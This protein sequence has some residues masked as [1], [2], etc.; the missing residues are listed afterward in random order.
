MGKFAR[1]NYIFILLLVL[2][3]LVGCKPE[4]EKKDTSGSYTVTDIQGTTVTIPAKPKRILT[5]S[6]ST[7]EMMLGLVEPERMVAVNSLLDD[8][9]SSNM[10]E[11]GKQVPTKIKYPSVEE[12]AALQPDLVIEP[13]WGDLSRV[14]ALRDL[15]IPVVVCKGPK[16]LQDIKETI[17]L[18]AQAVGEPQRGDILLKKM[19]EKLGEIKSKVAEIPQSERKS[20]LLISLMKDYGGAGCAFDEACQL[21]GVINGAAAAGIQNGQIMTK[22]K[23]VAINPDF[24]FLPS[25]NNHGEVDINRIRSEYINDPGLQGMKAIKNGALLMPDEGYIY[26]CSQD[27]VFAVQ[28][29]AYRVYGDKFKLEPQQHLSAVER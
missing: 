25:Y 11:L 4:G 15:G 14:A 29:I 21:A 10:V 5:M 19:D 16:N 1:W 2:I 28:E 18:L 9:S 12:I 23:M 24:L 8:P 22:E 7:D 13:D 6:M 27:F 20:V 26:N 17:A 3:S